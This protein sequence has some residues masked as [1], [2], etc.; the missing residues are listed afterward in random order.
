MMVKRV[1]V[2]D[3][4]MCNLL[5]VA[6]AFEHFGAKVSVVDNPAEASGADRLVVPGVGAFKE[7]IAE[8]RARGF[9]DSIREFAGSGRPMLGICVG[10]QMLFDASEEF[11]ETRGLGILKGRVVA[12][13]AQTTA[14]EAQRV[15]HIGWNHL[16]PSERG[17]SWAG[18]LLA[19]FEDS[20]PAMYFVHS[21]AARAAD[22]GD[23]LAD[24]V[25]GGHRVCAAVARDNIT[26]FQFHPERSGR[27]GLRVVEAFLAR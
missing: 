17:R 2:L 3:Y 1:T 4:G 19:G 6:R 14:G 16:V 7:C 21:F 13:P 15:P 12:V 24:C 20:R 22:A 26:A 8:V 27:D 11:G 10:M 9:D 25:Y 23:V 18:S 5:N